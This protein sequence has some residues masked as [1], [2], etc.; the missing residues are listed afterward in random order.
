MAVN[1]DAADLAVIAADAAA[2]CAALCVI[3]AADAL[4]V[5]SADAAA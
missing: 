3:I 5:F 1:A 2:L 4:G